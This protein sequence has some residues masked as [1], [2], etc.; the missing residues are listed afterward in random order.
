M[1]PCCTEPWLVSVEIDLQLTAHFLHQVGINSRPSG[2]GIQRQYCI[3]TANQP[4]RLR[5][6][7][8]TT[9]TTTTR[10]CNGPP[11]TRIRLPLP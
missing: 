6:T 5:T 7:T 3:P 10:N 1:L 9:T 8:T 4:Q 11:N 2:K